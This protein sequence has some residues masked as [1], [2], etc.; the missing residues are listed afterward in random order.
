MSLETH[1]C[2]ECNAEVRVPMILPYKGGE[3]PT[4]MPLYYMDENQN[5]HLLGVL[6]DT[7]AF[8]LCNRGVVAIGYAGFPHSWDAE[9]V[10]PH[11]FPY[12]EQN[13]IPCRC[14]ICEEE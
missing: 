11:D 14:S 9:V 4:G 8:Q 2:L 12:E 5:R 6:C 10:K 1:R 13:Q 3:K 7:C